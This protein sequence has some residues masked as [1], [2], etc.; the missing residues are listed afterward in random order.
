MPEPISKEKFTEFLIQKKTDIGFSNKNIANL[1]K[2]TKID[3]SN[4][5]QDQINLIEA[6][7]ESS[8]N[9]FYKAQMLNDLIESHP[10]C[11]IHILNNEELTNSDIFKIM[12]KE[13]IHKACVHGLHPNIIDS[14]LSKKSPLTKNEKQHIVS[15]VFENA[16]DGNKKDIKAF[17]I[18]YKILIIYLK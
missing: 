3:I 7:Q 6:I 2:D 1:L 8:Y 11:I 17:C 16:T 12:D 18:K 9:N 4:K 15:S 5:N 13:T 14:A 10:E